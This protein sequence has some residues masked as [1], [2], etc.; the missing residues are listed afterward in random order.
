MN[1]SLNKPLC[2]FDLETTGL[3]VTKDR[4]VQIAVIKINPDGLKEELNLIVNPE[5]EIPQEVIDI[6]GITNERA[7]ECPTFKE[8]AV[9]VATFIGNSDL[10]G[11]NSNKFDIPV[12]AEEFLRVGVDF[13]LSNRAFIDVQNIFHKMEQRTLVAAYKFYCEKDLNNAHD[14]MFDTIATWEVLEKQIEK[15]NLDSDVN[16]L[17]DLS[18]AGNH[19]IVDMAGRIAI[20]TKGEVIYNFGKHK[21]KTVE[22]ISKSEPG[23]YGWML[24]ADFPLYTK[25]VLRKAMESIKEANRLKENANL[26]DKLNALQNK[27]KK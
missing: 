19:K 23:Y 9:Q 13:D 3:Q 7:K 26:D 15:Y 18:R 10:V 5:M 8:L 11:F 1:I 6:H 14:A 22:Q 17:A 4:I 2:V 20:N 25:S 24:E 21:G 16:R 12:L 27:F